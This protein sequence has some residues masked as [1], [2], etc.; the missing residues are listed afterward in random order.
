MIE[1]LFIIMNNDKSST[2][3]ARY[4]YISMILIRIHCK[5]Y[6]KKRKVSGPNLWNHYSIHYSDIKIKFDRDG[7]KAENSRFFLFICILID[8]D[9]AR[10]CR[11]FKLNLLLPRERNSCYFLP[12]RRRI[13]SKSKH[14]SGFKYLSFILE[15]KKG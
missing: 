5:N 2:W 10:I 3:I 7:I 12:P 9:S 13:Y 6:K 4:S 15:H 11:Y 8:L 14:T 1:H